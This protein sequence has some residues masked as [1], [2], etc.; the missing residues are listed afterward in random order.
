MRRCAVVA[1]TLP[2]TAEA[3][4]R[5]KLHEL[6]VRGYTVHVVTSPGPELVSLRERVDDV[7]VVPMAREISL[8]SD[9]TALLAWIRVLREVRPELVFAGTPKAGL[10]AMISARVCRVPRRVYFLQGLRLEGTSGLKRRVLALTERLASWC[11]HTV[12][13]VSPS[14]AD[15]YVRLGL[16][17][18]RA[19][20][21]AHHGSSHGVDSDH[22][23]PRPKDTALLVE[24]G[25]DP[26]VPTLAFIGRLTHDKGPETIVDALGLLHRAG[27]TVQ[28]LVVGTQDEP[29]S[30]RIAHELERSPQRVRVV[31]QVSDVRPF[32]AACDL[33]VLPTM[34]EGLPNVVL[35]AAAMGL[36]AI[37][38]T[39]TGAVD[40][41]VPGATGLLFDY[42]DTQGL[43]RAIRSLTGDPGAR[44]SMGDAARQRV[45]RDFQPYDVARSIIDLA[46]GDADAETPGPTS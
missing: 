40:S 24:L 32:L 25:L 44:S 26:D 16:N 14:L 4:Y 12:V 19:V 23:R 20:L 38:T 13:A 2:R 46:I 30:R 1:T 37:T 5:E 34:R 9:A 18:G 36:P 6:G 28:L 41:V 31:D 29:D 22:F 21:V 7:R 35:E 27:E 45:V 42:G 33:L 11:S 39:A 15:E 17:A 43:V 3:F 10:I 8:G